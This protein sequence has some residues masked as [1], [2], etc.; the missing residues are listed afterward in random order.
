MGVYWSHIII[1]ILCFAVTVAQPIAMEFKTVFNADNKADGSAAEGNKVFWTEPS[2]G[3]VS[4]WFLLVGV[5]GL[6]LI[7]LESVN[8]VGWGVAW[9]NRVLAWTG[10]LE[11]GLTAA[12]AVGLVE[13]STTGAILAAVSLGVLLASVYTRYL[14]TSRGNLNK[15]CALLWIGVVIAGLLPLIITFGTD[16]ELDPEQQAVSEDCAYFGTA[17]SFERFIC[18][19][20]TLTYTIAILVMVAILA[21]MWLSWL[22]STFC[23]ICDN[24]NA[25]QSSGLTSSR[26]TEAAEAAPFK[27]VA[28]DRIPLLSL[29]VRR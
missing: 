24:W 27:S 25:S 20:R 22:L 19:N 1:L 7:G 5:A 12:S 14:F 21:F 28:S 9:G 15:I 17:D 10:S 13:S 11:N 26:A 29:R 4:T 16:F 23:T 3:R 8:A 18:E 2:V 6:V